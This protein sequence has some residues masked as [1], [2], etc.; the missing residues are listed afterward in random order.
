MSKPQLLDQAYNERNQLVAALSR[1]YPAHLCIDS[2]VECGWQHVV[3][4]HIRHWDMIPVGGGVEV[5]CTS[6]VT[7]HIP[8]RELEIFAHLQFDR[9]HFDGHSTDLKYRRLKRIL[10]PKK[11][12][13]LWW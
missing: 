10:P 7:W 5:T 9:N 4:I 1:L 12:R 13:F 11:R 8:D 6:Q 2:S 3:C